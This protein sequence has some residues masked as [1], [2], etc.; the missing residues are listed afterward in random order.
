MPQ[1][2]GSP[3]SNSR[4][5]T[6]T[7]PHSHTGKI[8]PNRP[9]TKVA[10]NRFFGKKRVMTREGTNAAMNPEINDPTKTNGNPSKASAR[11]ENQKFSQLTWN[12]LIQPTTA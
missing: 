2:S 11:N 5:T 8:S 9:L 4:R 3:L 6:G 1:D 12:Q 10:R 7:T